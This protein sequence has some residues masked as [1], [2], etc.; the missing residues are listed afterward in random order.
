MVIMHSY[1]IDDGIK[2]TI[3]RYYHALIMGER[4]HHMVTSERSSSNSGLIEMS[5]LI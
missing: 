2:V 3:S 1:I 4:L 5:D